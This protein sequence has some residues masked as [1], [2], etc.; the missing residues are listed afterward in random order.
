MIPIGSQLFPI[1]SY[2]APHRSSTAALAMQRGKLVQSAEQAPAAAAPAAA[3]P[4]VDKMALVVAVPV[5]AAIPG[6]D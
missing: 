3:E 4:Q 5:P 1:V 6:A 2:T